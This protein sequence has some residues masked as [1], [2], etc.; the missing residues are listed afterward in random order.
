MLAAAAAGR[1]L[2]ARYGRPDEGAAPR[3]ESYTV[4][5]VFGLLA[6]LQGF[7]FALA[8]ERFEARRILV[9]DEAN[10]IRTAYFRVQVLDEPYRERL[11]GLLE[12]YIDNRVALGGSRRADAAPLVM[13]D[14]RLVAQIESTVEALFPTVRDYDF[15]STLFEGMNRVIE[16]GATRAEERLTRVPT[17]V[18]I[19]LMAY[20]TIAAGVLGYALIGRHSRAIGFI[21]I[22]LFGLSMLLIVDIDRPS[23]G[24]I[25]ESQAAMERLQRT[26]A[27]RPD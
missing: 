11:S 1:R 5:A 9:I 16:L 2:R 8:V 23:I 15:S 19:V 17:E 4:S 22:V 6:L 7:T 13:T 10:A 12:D 18:I 26:L 24:G 20:Q 14:A 3:Q 27:L 25:R 21:L